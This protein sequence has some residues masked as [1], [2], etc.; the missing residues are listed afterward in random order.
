MGLP[1]RIESASGTRCSN[2]RIT[3][4]KIQ[5]EIGHFTSQL[6]SLIN[7]D[8]M[9]YTFDST[10]SKL[11]CKTTHCLSRLWSLVNSYEELH[12]KVMEISFLIFL[13]NIKNIHSLISKHYC[14]LQK[15]EVTTTMQAH[16]SVVGIYLSNL[17]EKVFAMTINLCIMIYSVIF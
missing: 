7:H 9:T 14:L 6:E 15:P 10:S 11:L 13:N 17:Y 4:Q 2:L 12:G 8:P 1:I 5:S 16:L 3:P